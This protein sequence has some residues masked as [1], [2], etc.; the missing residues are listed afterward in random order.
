MQAEIKYVN[1][2]FESKTKIFV[3]ETNLVAYLKA[4][5]FMERAKDFAQLTSLR[6]VGGCKMKATLILQ[7]R[8]QNQGYSVEK[9]VVFGESRK[10]VWEKVK[11]LLNQRDALVASL[12][13]LPV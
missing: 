11:R 3:G 8:N 1:K 2:K 10:Q 5:K 4:L 7:K 12:T 6:L 13:I 9:L